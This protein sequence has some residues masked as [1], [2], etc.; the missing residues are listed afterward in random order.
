MELSGAEIL[1]E[2]AVAVLVFL[3]FSAG[4]HGVAGHLA[5]G[6]GIAWI[7]LGA[8]FQIPH[9]TLLQRNTAISAKNKSVSAG[10][11][12]ASNL[13]IA[14]GVRTR[15]PRLRRGREVTVESPSII[16]SPALATPR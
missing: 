16:D 13:N 10:Q 2:S 3:A 6:G 1:R 15:L 4:A 7:E 12:D 9:R 11:Y 14:V 8:L 5:P